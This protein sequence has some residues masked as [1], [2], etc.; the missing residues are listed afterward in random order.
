MI[1]GASKGAFHGHWSWSKHVSGDDGNKTC[2]NGENH[3]QIAKTK[4]Q[5]K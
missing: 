1:K 4:S 5:E 2:R 3:Q